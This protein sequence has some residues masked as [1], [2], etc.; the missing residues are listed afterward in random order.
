MLSAAHTVSAQD[1]SQLFNQAPADTAPAQDANQQSFS[2]HDISQSFNQMID[3]AKTV[4]L[5]SVPASPQPG[6]SVT[7]RATSPITPLANADITWSQNGVIKSHGVGQTTFTTTLESLGKATTIVFS[8]QSASGISMQKSLIFN[9]G[10]IDIVWEAHTTTPPFYRGKALPTR[11]SSVTFTALP[12]IIGA[13]GST[14]SSNG[15]IY[16]WKKDNQSLGNLSGYGRNSI[17]I[18]GGWLD[19]AS[20]YSVDAA[21][22]AGS[23]QNVPPTSGSIIYSPDAV[24]MILFY[25]RSPLDGVLYNHAFGGSQ[26]SFP[27]NSVVIRAEPYYFS[28]DLYSNPR[29]LFSWQLGLQPIPASEPLSNEVTFAEN[30]ATQAPSDIMLEINGGALFQD[31]QQTLT[32][33]PKVQ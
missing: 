1:I 19:H 32:I 16:T 21:T 14:L 25:E 22:L 13:G 31:A 29:A 12:T 27:S 2:A 33:V 7:I 24:P 3:I 15:L 20:T 10:I 5:T 17:T 28:S 11:G 4:I 6:E 8:A 9:P 18:P 26:A 23:A 30:S